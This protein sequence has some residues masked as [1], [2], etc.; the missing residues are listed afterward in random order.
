MECHRIKRRG[1]K[2]E[3]V[4]KDKGGNGRTGRYF[5]GRDVYVK[6]IQTYIRTPGT[7]LFRWHQTKNSKRKFVTLISSTNRIAQNIHAD[8]LTDISLG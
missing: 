2:A 3:K 6:E 5:A 7:T 4:R 8:R 1:N